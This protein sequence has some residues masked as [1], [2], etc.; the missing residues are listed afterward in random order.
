[1]SDPVK[2]KRKYNSGRHAT[3]AAE[4]R[5]AVV[6]A[7]RALF[8]SLGW[9][10]TTISGIARAAAVST[11]TVYATFR[12]KQTILQAV[13]EAAIRGEQPERPLLEQAGPSAIIEAANHVR[14]IELFA[15]DIGR[16][17]ANVADV[18]AV[19]RTAAET[20]PELA[21]L[22]ATLHE[23][24]R[25]N[26]RFVADALLQRGP[27]RNGMDSQQA[28]A[29]I[30]RLASP[31]LFLLLTNVEGLSVQQYGDWLSDALQ[32]VLLP[33]AR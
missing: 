14:Q 1:M 3:Q 32:C 25:R 13:V 8:V 31:E 9:Q 7:A 4:T 28:T 2:P 10:A 18:M 11:E 24:R 26:L 30:W 20:D 19:V 29:M 33:P 22:Y 17:L 16:I 6:N 21:G 27:L 15:H 12:N 5:T 23:G